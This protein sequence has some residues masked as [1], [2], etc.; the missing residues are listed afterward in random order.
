[1]KTLLL[2]SC[3][4]AYFELGSV[5]RPNHQAYAAARGYETRC[6]PCEQKEMMGGADITFA[7]LQAVQA[8]FAEGFEQVLTHGV[9][10]VFTNH[11]IALESIPDRLQWSNDRYLP[12]PVV[13]AREEIRWWPINLDVVIWR[14]SPEADALLRRLLV[15]DVI[16]RKLRWGLQQHIWNLLQTDADTKATVKIVPARTMNSTIQQCASRWQVG[17]FL[18]HFLDMP[19]HERV[20]CA[21]MIL[22]IAGP[23]DG[24]FHG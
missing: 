2:T 4:Q 17:D 10:T 19:L 18:C 6:L 12:W 24:T 7:M 21:K 14:S 1:M 22:K 3:S 23:C 20:E 15:D 5:T 13:I 11:A 16:W 8:A 9:D